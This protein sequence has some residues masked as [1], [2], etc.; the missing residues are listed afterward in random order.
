MSC[1]CYLYELY[2]MVFA[3]IFS[4]VVFLIIYFIT[5]AF[6]SS[7]TFRY[8]L[9]R[10]A[11]F[12]CG[13]REVRIYGKIHPKTRVF[14]FNHPTHLDGYIINELIPDTYALARR[15]NLLV[16]FG[17][18]DQHVVWV[19]KKGGERTRDRI[20][21]RMN[22]HPNSRISI[23]LH[24]MDKCDEKDL[25]G[26]IKGDQIRNPRTIAFSLGHQVQPVVLVYDKCPK[27]TN[28]TSDWLQIFRTPLMHAGYSVSAYILPPL[29][30][31]PKETAKQFAARS[32]VLMN[33]VLNRAWDHRV[34][35]PSAQDIDIWRSKSLIFSSMLFLTIVVH[36]WKKKQW[37]LGFLWLSALLA[38]MICYSHMSK[39][40]GIAHVLRYGT[41][42]LATIHAI[43]MLASKKK[44]LGTFAAV[45]LITFAVMLACDSGGLFC[46]IAKDVAIL[47]HHYINHILT[48]INHFLLIAI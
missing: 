46:C 35:E 22:I 37:S 34:P 41:L 8:L 43:T 6:G 28:W 29:K 31:R 21:Q 24:S 17:V 18:R 15:G 4:F 27:I 30:K 12:A 3:R 7:F 13:I 38:S 9:T 32:I 19:G 14:P 20:V 23:A 40:P 11:L 26:R 44:K 45:M 2:V 36:A 1:F 42:F 48:L 16:S 33:R 25:G 47:F 39:H 10:L 5:G